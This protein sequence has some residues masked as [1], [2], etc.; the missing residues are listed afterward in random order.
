[1]DPRLDALESVFRDIDGVSPILMTTHLDDS[2]VDGPGLSPSGLYS[3]WLGSCGTTPAAPGFSC[4][5]GS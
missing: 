5:T 4:L 1:M 3:A 2:L